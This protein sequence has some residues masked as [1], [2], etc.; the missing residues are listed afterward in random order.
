MATKQGRCPNCGSILMVD[1]Q[2]PVGICIFCQARYAPAQ[3]IQLDQ[4]PGDHE[5]KNEP[6]AELTEEEKRLAYANYGNIHAPSSASSAKKTTV[7]HKKKPADK[8]TPTQRVALMKKELVEPKLSRRHQVYMAAIIVG[9]IL[10]SVAVILPLTLSKKAKRAE[11]AAEIDQ[12]AGFEVTDP[13]YY[14]FSG[15]RNQSLLLIYNGAVTEQAA[16]D[17]LQQFKQARSQVY[18]L[19]PDNE[20]TSTVLRM[21][22]TNGS[23]TIHGN[24]ATEFEESSAEISATAEESSETAVASATEQTAG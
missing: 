10:I 3:A 23:V 13:A 1:E 4:N 7:Q 14:A 22:G 9:I 20:Q 21:A 6:Q 18:N 5:F 8:L 19:D 16:A 12:I 15:Q 11:L 24:G 2:A 17:V